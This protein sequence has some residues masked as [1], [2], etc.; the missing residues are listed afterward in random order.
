MQAIA[1]AKRLGATVEAFDIRTATKGEVE[2][3]GGKFIE[4]DLESLIE[5][6]DMTQNVAIL[7]GDTVVISKSGMC[8]VTGEVNTPGSYP[9][10]EGTTVLQLIALAGGFNGKASKSSVRIVRFIDDEKTVLKNVDLDTTFVEDEDVIVV[11]E[12]FF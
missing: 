12:S 3:L 1:T 11:P 5:G 9:C 4:I 8:Y 2:S 10:G 7:D 6:G